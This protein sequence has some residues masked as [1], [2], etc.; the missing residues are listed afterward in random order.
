M[1]VGLVGI[2]VCPRSAVPVGTEE[3]AVQL[4]GIDTCDD[5]A[6]R[7]LGAI[8]QGD[9]ALLLCHSGSIFTEA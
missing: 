1:A 2:M 8:I 9:T 5:V 4:V 6:G 3:D 7:H